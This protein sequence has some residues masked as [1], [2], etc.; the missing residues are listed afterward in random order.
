MFVWLA[1]LFFL[2][3]WNVSNKAVLNA[4]CKIFKNVIYHVRM[5][6]KITYFYRRRIYMFKTKQLYKFQYM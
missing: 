3:V 6:N 2:H 1:D 5:E 4:F